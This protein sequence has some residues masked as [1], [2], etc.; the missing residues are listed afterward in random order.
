[1][2]R[3]PPRSTVFPYTTLFRSTRNAG[4]LRT[5]FA[6]G[7]VAE[8]ACVDHPFSVTVGD[9]LRHRRMIAGVP[10]GWAEAIANLS[11]GERQR[12]AR[13]LVLRGVRRRCSC[14]L[15]PSGC[16]SCRS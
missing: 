8:A 7:I 3:R 6:V 9:D 13:K 12:A 10:V 15:A 4:V 5:A 11:N 2:M 1:M 14:A 16:G